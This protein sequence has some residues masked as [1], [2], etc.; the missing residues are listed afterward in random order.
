VGW[1]FHT[2]GLGPHQ[3]TFVWVEKMGESVEENVR[4]LQAYPRLRHNVFV[5]AEGGQAPVG[6]FGGDVTSIGG[7]VSVMMV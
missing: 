5:V 3:K 1:V 2:A 7:N 6:V 4:S